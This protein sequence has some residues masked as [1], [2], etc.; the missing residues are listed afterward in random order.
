ML[1]LF[2]AFGIIAII[3]KKS[4]KQR[5]ESILPS[6]ED[7]DMEMSQ[8]SMYNISR[9][10]ANNRNDERMY[11]ANKAEGIIE[12]IQVA[13]LKFCMNVIHCLQLL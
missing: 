10:A 6:A 5:K 13:F 2:I 4:N 7:T 11:P 8:N 12:K 1:L 9:P 3:F